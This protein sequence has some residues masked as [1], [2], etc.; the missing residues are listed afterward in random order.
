[1]ISFSILHGI[2]AEYFDGGDQM[3][4]LCDCGEHEDQVRKVDSPSTKF[5]NKE[6]SDG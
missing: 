1:M 4:E 3:V 6:R 2:V 5:F